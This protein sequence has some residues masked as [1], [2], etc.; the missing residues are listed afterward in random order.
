MLTKPTDKEILALARISR[1]LDGKILKE[2][3]VRALDDVRDKVMVADTDTLIRR[4]QGRG[5]AL[6]DFGEALEMA[7]DLVVKLENRANGR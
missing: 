6:K 1:S 5:E 7:P 4:L 3:L 2:Y